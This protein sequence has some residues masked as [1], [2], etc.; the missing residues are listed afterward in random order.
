MKSF[1]IEKP[2]KTE[3]QLEEC[4]AKLEKKYSSQISE[5]N[6]S[7]KKNGNKY[8]L[9]AE[10][11]KFFMNFRIDVN[12]IISNGSIKLEYDSNVPSKY[13]KDAMKMIEDEINSECA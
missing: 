12:L 2:G 11:S 6:I 10:V 9:H 13:E 4:L 7:I 3:K 1:V 5:N 8:V